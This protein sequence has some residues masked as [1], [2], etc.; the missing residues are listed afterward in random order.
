MGWS[1]TYI[2]IL[3]ETLIFMLSRVFFNSPPIIGNLIVRDVHKTL[4]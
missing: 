3:S 4:A 2:D 1:Q